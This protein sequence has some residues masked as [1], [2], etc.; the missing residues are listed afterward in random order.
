MYLVR[1]GP[2]QTIH[3]QLETI[4]ILGPI[5]QLRWGISYI[6]FFSSLKLTS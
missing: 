6:M 2:D 3:F 5:D 1:V 4:L